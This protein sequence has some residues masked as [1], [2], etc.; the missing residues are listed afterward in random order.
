MPNALSPLLMRLKTR[1]EF[2]NGPQPA[3]LSINPR[4]P[5]E[6]CRNHHLEDIERRLNNEACDSINKG[7][8]ERVVPTAPHPAVQTKYLLRPQHPTHS[9]MR[10]DPSDGPQ[11]V[12]LSA[13]TWPLRKAVLPSFRKSETVP[14]RHGCLRMLKN[15]R[16]K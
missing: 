11:T 14:R 10:Y 13:P 6:S 1:S 4:F 15:E 7:V 3:V 9:N 2:P 12:I 5:R 16:Y 8:S